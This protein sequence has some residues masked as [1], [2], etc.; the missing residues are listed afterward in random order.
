MPMLPDCKSYFNGLAAEWDGRMVIQPAL[1]SAVAFFAGARPGV[2]ALDIACG[3]GITFDY[4]LAQGIES[5]TAIDISDEM[6]RIAQAKYAHDSRVT[7]L[8]GDFLQLEAP[9]F[10]CALLYNAYPH[11][12]DK[13]ALLA[14]AAAL[15]KPGGRFTVA[16]GMGRKTLN[17]RHQDVPPSVS[18]PLGPAQGET[19]VWEPW[20]LVDIQLSDGE[21]YVI[22]GLRND[23]PAVSAVPAT[24]KR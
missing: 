18:V 15:L 20:F 9:P 4:L 11:F 8:T 12:L 22:S 1:L 10:D 2:R 13:P 5:L 21:K 17:S 14:H 24:D 6:A 23:A 19:A 7:V 16:H 3:T